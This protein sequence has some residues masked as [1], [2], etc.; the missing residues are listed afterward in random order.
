MISNK[1]QEGKINRGRTMNLIR[2]RPG[3]SRIEASE[4]L[5][6]NRSTMTHIVNDLLQSEF[7]REEK[8]LRSGDKGGRLPIGLFAEEKH[9]LGVEW[10][11]GF[12]R[13]TMNNLSGNSIR[14][15]QISLCDNSFNCFEKQAGV[16]IDALVRETGFT[17]YGLGL[18]LPGR[19]DPHKGIVLESTP[20]GLKNTNLASNLSQ[21]L[22]MPVLIEND[23]NCFAW[24]EIAE[25]RD[26]QGNLLCML[27]EF[28]GSGNTKD[29]DQE[30][31][32]GLVCGGEVYHGSSYSSGELKTSPVN[33]STRMDFLK[34]L[35]QAD[36]QPNNLAGE[37]CRQMFSS[38]QPVIATF[39]PELLVLGGDF[40]LHRSLLE[41]FLKK[42]IPFKWKFSEKG[43]LE[44]ASGGA[45]FFIKTIFSF[46]G[47]NESALHKAE[48]ENILRSRQTGGT[49][50]E[51]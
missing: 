36:S 28:H 16:L 29:W 50:A 49:S 24:G 6:L 41:P 48:W 3:I 11:G 14:Q 34:L 44:V 13:Y 15:G 12:L 38:L 20:L 22:G 19:V 35:D 18:A 25:R 51:R 40:Y 1:V 8:S 5:G 21:S 43:I 27:L 30:I 39:D 31:G 46:S 26:F 10:Q 37:Y 7:I 42:E 45:S 17:V 4:L 32:I 2:T 47:I 33:D 9:V 23:A